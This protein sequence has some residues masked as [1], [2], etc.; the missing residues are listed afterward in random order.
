MTRCLRRRHPSLA[1][2]SSSPSRYLGVEAALSRLQG[3]ASLSWPR[4]ESAL[5]HPSIALPPPRAWEAAAAAL[6]APQPEAAA[7]PP[8]APSLSHKVLAKRGALERLKAR[9]PLAVTE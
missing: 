2:G 8:P 7:R 4:D 6:V 1:A 5:L 3:A 9:A